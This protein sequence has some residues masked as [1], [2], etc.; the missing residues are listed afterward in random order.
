[1]H[2]VLANCDHIAV[3][4]PVGIMGTAYRK[5]DQI[6]QPWQFGDSYEKQTALWLKGI[7]ALKP[8]NIVAKPERVKYASGKTMPK[9]YA[10]LWHS[11]DRATLRSKTFP[12]IAKAMAEQWSAYILGETNE[13]QG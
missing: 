4:N 9:W 5:A 10:D 1:M 7:P 13:T 3:E 6:I 12:G 2:F 11:Q 8:T